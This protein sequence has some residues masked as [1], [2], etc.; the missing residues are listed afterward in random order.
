MGLVNVACVFGG[1]P[2][3]HGSGG[4]AGQYKFGGRT[5]L[6][7]VILG[8]VKVIVGLAGG[9]WFNTLLKFFPNSVLGIFIIYM[10]C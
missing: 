6:C 10:W 4:L 2:T 7:V 8:I 9:M 5:G 1:I 3:C